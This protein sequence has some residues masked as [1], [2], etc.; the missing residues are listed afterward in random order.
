MAVS[1]DRVNH[2]RLMAK[3]AERVSDK[4]LLK[5]IRVFLQAGVME[6]GLVNP[7]DEFRKAGLCRPCCRT[8]CSTSSTGSWNGAASGLRG[9][10][11]IAISTFAA[12][13]RGNE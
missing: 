9:M 8:S 2:D 11:T 4:R 5:L 13:E 1:F 10:R 12:G 6:G 7:V 3:I